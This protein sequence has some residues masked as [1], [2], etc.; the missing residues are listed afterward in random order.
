MPKT[1]IPDLTDKQYVPHIYESLTLVGEEASIEAR[2]NGYII[3]D[4]L[5]DFPQIA[6]KI[7]PDQAARLSRFL[8]RMGRGKCG[9]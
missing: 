9:E 8:S 7:T 2:G 5:D 3:V 1:T 6:I 4:S